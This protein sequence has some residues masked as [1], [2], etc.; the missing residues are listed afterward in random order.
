VWG[1]SRACLQAEHPHLFCLRSPRSSD[2]GWAYGRGSSSAGGALPNGAPRQPMYG[3]HSAPPGG[4]G[5]PPPPPPGQAGRR[6]PSP[7]GLPPHLSLMLDKQG[8]SLGI[9]GPSA[10]GGGDPAAAMADMSLGGGGGSGA[11]AAAAAAAAGAQQVYP[12]TNGGHQMVPRPAVGPAAPVTGPAGAPVRQGPLLV[13]DLVKQLAGRVDLL[14]SLLRCPICRVRR[15]A[16]GERPR[17]GARTPRERGGSA[18]CLVRL[19]ARTPPQARARPLSAP[20]APPTTRGRRRCF[21]T[22]SSRVTGR[23]TVGGARSLQTGA[24]ARSRPRRKRAFR[25]R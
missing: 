2:P 12:M 15:G 18:P 6:V 11:A 25:R 5:G 10:S 24:A 21:G 22:R 20:R 16:G 23:P 7:G 19:C 1:P 3:Q 4:P 17:P 8:E 9:T 13:P 14:T